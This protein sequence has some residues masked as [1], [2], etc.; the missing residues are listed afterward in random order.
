MQLKRNVIFIELKV[1]TTPHYL[2]SNIMIMQ[3]LPNERNSQVWKQNICTSEL[4][5]RRKYCDE[6][7]GL[8][9]A[10]KI[11]V[12]R[13]ERQNAS[14]HRRKGKRKYV[15][16]L[17]EEKVNTDFRTRLSCLPTVLAHQ[18]PHYQL[19]EWSLRE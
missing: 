9:R 3:K 4:F 18:L 16:T 2:S 14:L 6:A 11:V 1:S 7:A 19:D 8:E 10:E 15:V 13:R 5:D 12:A 17:K